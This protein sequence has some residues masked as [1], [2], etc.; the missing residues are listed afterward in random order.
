[1][2]IFATSPDPFECARYLD[3]KRVISQ[4]KET[5]QMLSTAINLNGGEGP[6]K[7]AHPH[8]PCTKWVAENRSNYIWLIDHFY[9]LLEE[10]KERRGKP[11]K[12]EALIADLEIGMKIIPIGEQTPFVN[13]AAR[14]DMGICYK[15]IDNVHEAYKLYL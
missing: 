1:M 8:H 3:D 2:N 6:L 14:K 12:Y 7:I 10:F 9:A 4:T 11:H 5:G 15:H 13:A